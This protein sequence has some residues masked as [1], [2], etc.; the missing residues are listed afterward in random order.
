MQKAIKRKFFIAVACQIQGVISCLSWFAFY[1]KIY[2]AQSTSRRLLLLQ[3][4]SFCEEFL[5]ILY[6]VGG[7][8]SNNTHYD[9][10]SIIVV[11]DLG[12]GKGK[13]VFAPPQKCDDFSFLPSKNFSFSLLPRIFQS[14]FISKF[15]LVFMHFL[16]N[17]QLVGRLTNFKIYNSS[18]CASKEW[19]TN[20][21]DNRNNMILKQRRS[22]KYRIA[23]Y[24]KT[25][26]LYI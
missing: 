6:I 4:F 14:T 19:L 26:F 13:V 3:W 15:N 9:M 20:R 11:L 1:L 10:M 18:Q 2:H 16:S 8:C 25:F 17:T 22:P 23:E 7:Q 24:W 5:R 12:V 21:L